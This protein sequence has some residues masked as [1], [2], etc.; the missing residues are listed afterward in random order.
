MTKSHKIK[1]DDPW[2]LTQSDI[3]IKVTNF[4]LQLWRVF[5]GFIRWQEECE[6][7]VNNTGLTANEIAVLHI[8]RMKERPKTIYD[9]GRL[10]NRDDTFNIHYSIRKLLKMGLIKKTK[11][12]QA[13]KKTFAYQTSDAGTKNTDTFTE[14]RNHILLEMYSQEKELNLVELAKAL[15]KVNA[16]YDEADRAVASY[17][18]P[19]AEE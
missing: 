14:M 8:I 1:T 9:I 10:L 7:G 19:P 3:G 16:L 15:S 18:K 2:H 17:T 13:G 12:D 4:E 6:R 11:S 5:Y